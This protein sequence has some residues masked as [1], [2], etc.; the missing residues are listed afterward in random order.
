MKKSAKPVMSC[1]SRSA[2][3]S[4]LPEVGSRCAAR[5]MIASVEKKEK[6][7]GN[8][9]QAKYA[10]EYCGKVEAELD[11][12]CKTVLGDSRRVQD[13]LPED[14][15]RPLPVHRRVPRW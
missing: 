15:G 5:R 1:L 8:E 14:Q 7:K 10:K 11:K 4:P 6:T 12:I 9:E 3:C 2:T 13:P